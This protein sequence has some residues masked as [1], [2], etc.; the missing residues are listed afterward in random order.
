MCM[1]KLDFGFD[2]G[3]YLRILMTLSRYSE[4]PFAV[5]ESWDFEFDI[6]IR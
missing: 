5:V 3:R 1:V 2:D 4:L 6:Q